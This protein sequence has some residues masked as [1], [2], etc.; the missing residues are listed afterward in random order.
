M[1][2]GA[3]KF[4]TKAEVKNVNSFRYIRA[5]LE[6]E[7]GRQ[8]EVLES[9]SRVVQESRLW[10][11]AE[12]RTYSMRSK[13]QAH[14]YRYFPEPDLVPVEP[15]AEILDA[16]RS[17]MPE[18]P[19]ARAQRFERELGLPADRARL[20]AFRTEL[21]DF[22]E[23]ALMSDGAG[24]DPVALANWIPPLL[25]RIGSDTDPAQTRVSP[26]SL[27][28]LV[29]LVSARAVSQNAARDVLTALVAEG[30][31]PATIVEREGLAPISGEGS[32]L[33]EIV[34]AAL[35][36]DPAAAERVRTG[37][38]KAIGP[39]VGYVMRETKGRADGGEV[40]RLIREQ[41]G[42]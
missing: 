1:L 28:R 20:L 22:Y 17:A 12:S 31:D 2:K 6:Y 24:L 19:A 4:G 9:G 33:A 16:A 26:A 35:A 27:A 40:T 11:N 5:A 42:G 8:I 23:Q 15:T 34:A 32:G 39:L 41:L 38:M 10:N 14:D 37:N 18:L 25:E 21:G 7:I 3:A 29:Q 30:G 36:A 13:E